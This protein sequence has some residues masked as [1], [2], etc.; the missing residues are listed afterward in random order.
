MHIIIMEIKNH[1]NFLSILKNFIFY[2]YNCMDK[3]FPKI[4]FKFI[5][6]LQCTNQTYEYVWLFH[7][8]TFY[9]VIKITI[10]IVIL[11]QCTECVLNIF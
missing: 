8:N 9:P 2:E 1:K 4:Y 5:L 10:P 3:I 6:I 11:I 7:Y